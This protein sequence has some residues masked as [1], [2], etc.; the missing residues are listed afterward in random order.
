MVF[1]SECRATEKLIHPFYL[2]LAQ[3]AHTTIKITTLM[4]LTNKT[5]SRRRKMCIKMTQSKGELAWVEESKPRERASGLKRLGGRV[6]KQSEME[7]NQR[8]LTD[9]T[10]EYDAWNEPSETIKLPIHLI[11][12]SEKF[13]VP[14]VKRKKIRTQ[15]KCLYE[16]IKRVRN[17]KKRLKLMNL[18]FYS[19]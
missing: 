1:S 17:K 15:C 11:Q 2:S 14:V 16:I 7:E 13:I 10:N 3:R 6:K 19:A 4:T 9:M 5:N 12:F 18:M 8:R